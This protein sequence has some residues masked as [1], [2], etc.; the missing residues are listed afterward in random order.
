MATDMKTE[1]VTLLTSP[2]FKAFLHAEAEREKVSVAEF[3][4]NRCEQGVTDEEAILAALTHELSMAIAEAKKALKSGLDEAQ[5]VL[6]E[7]RSQREAMALP[8]SL[9]HGAGE[10]RT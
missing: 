7:L 9:G 3:V 4:R 6:E 1:R 5:A 10:V 2:A 8:S